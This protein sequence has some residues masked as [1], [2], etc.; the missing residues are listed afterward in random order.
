MLMTAIRLCLGLFLVATAL[1]AWLRKHRQRTAVTARREVLGQ[2]MLGMF[3]SLPPLAV[4]PNLSMAQN[5]RSATAQNMKVPASYSAWQEVL[6]DSDMF[7]QLHPG[8]YRLKN[9]HIYFVIYPDM[10]AMSR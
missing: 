7:L 5:P 10:S 4:H 8:W 9:S 1:A 2:I 6:F 3:L